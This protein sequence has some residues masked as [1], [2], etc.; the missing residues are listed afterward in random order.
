MKK[1]IIIICTLLMITAQPANAFRAGQYCKTSD[2]F[3]IQKASNNKMIQCIQS[4]TAKRF[5]WVVVK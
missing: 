5:R 3:K 1:I 2:A 4:G